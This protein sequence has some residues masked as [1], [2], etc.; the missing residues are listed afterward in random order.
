MV[1][2]GW[3]SFS[4]RW[5]HSSGRIGTNTTGTAGRAC[6]TACRYGGGRQVDREV[7]GHV[8]VAEVDGVERRDELDGRDRER[9]AGD[10][11]RQPGPGVAHPPPEE[12]GDEDG[13]G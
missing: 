4:S 10:R 1:R 8:I 11:A 5:Y 2:S 12:L 13:P 3:C 6:P 9:D 7:V